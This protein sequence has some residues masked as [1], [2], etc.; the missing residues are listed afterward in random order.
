MKLNVVIALMITVVTLIGCKKDDEAKKPA[1]YFEYDG[2]TYELA[3][4]FLE[5]WGPTP[6][7]SFNLD[8]ILLSDSFVLH[9]TG[10]VLD[11]ITGVGDGLYF[12]M[13]AT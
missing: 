13:F 1:S 9:E 12:E 4:G 10:E 3:N 11:S 8:L 2:K 5:N 6:V 7:S